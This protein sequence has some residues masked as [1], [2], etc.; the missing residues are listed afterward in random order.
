MFPGALLRQ[1]AKSPLGRET[2]GGF[3]PYLFA[4]LGFATGIPEHPARRWTVA[5]P[6]EDQ[7]KRGTAGG[8][9]PAREGGREGKQEGG[10]G[11]PLTVVSLQLR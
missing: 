6:S 2:S 10:T 7:I 3:R 1:A 4:C 9:T 8:G 5:F 11:Y